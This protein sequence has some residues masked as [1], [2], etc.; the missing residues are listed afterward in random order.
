MNSLI[1]VTCILLIS[2]EIL[3]NIHYLGLRLNFCHG[4]CRTACLVVMIQM[5][6]LCMTLFSRRGKRNLTKCKPN[7]SDVNGNGLANLLLDPSVRT[8]DMGRLNARLTWLPFSL[9]NRINTTLLFSHGTLEIYW[10][11]LL[12]ANCLR[13]ASFWIWKDSLYTSHR[14]LPL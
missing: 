13:H 5:T 10:G 12:T 14:I 1:V 9:S 2:T 6:T 7:K 3:V 4:S 8:Q 11:S